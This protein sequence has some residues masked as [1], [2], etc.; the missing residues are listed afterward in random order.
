MK[1]SWAQNILAGI[2][3]LIFPCFSDP[4]YGQED[5]KAMKDQGTFRQNLKKSSAETFSITSE[6][7]QTKH[8]D[9]LE[10]DVESKGRF[11]FEKEDKL[12][13]EYSTPFYYL[14]IF[15][16]DSV[17]ISNDEKTNT[18]NA[19]SG[20]MFKEISNIMVS[21]VDG[22]ILESDRFTCNYFEDPDAYILELTPQ[23]ANMKAFLSKVRIYISKTDYTA[24]ELYMLEHSGDYTYIKFINKRLNEKIPD[25]IFEL[26]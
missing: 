15:N 1:N 3:I 22:S 19:S 10:E 4:G 9:F 23:D 12:R 11:Y 20:R 17:I 16:G 5:H 2:L 13:W 26:P 6:F 18:F 7:V 25:Q 21:M 14:I 24:E 8:L